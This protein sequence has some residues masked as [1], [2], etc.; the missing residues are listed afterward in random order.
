MGLHLRFACPAKDQL[1][2]G[3]AQ[4]V[5]LFRTTV[6]AALLFGEECGDGVLLMW[7]FCSRA[8]LGNV[9]TRSQVCWASLHY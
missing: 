8:G 5:A 7:S 3:G 6:G 4:N 2:L 1:A 9:R